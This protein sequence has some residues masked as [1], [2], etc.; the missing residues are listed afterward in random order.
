MRIHKFG[1]TQLIGGVSGCDVDLRWC[2]ER[3]EEELERVKLPGESLVVD[4]KIYKNIG[5]KKTNIAL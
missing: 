1:I 4:I 2:T 5:L 3:I